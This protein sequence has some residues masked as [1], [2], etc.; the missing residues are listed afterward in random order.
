MNVVII[1]GGTR[2]LVLIDYFQSIDYIKIKGVVDTNA[3]APGVVRAKGLGIYTFTDINA[4]NDI[5]DVDTVIEVTGN[6]KARRTLIDLLKPNQHFMSS[7]AAKIMTDF[8][9]IQNLRRTEA[10]ESVSGEFN[11]LVST[12]KSSEEYIE[13]SMFKIE[14]VLQSM[15]IVTMN[16]RIEAARAGESGKAFDVVVQAMQDTLSNIEKVLRDIN[17]ASDESKHTIAELIETEKKLKESLTVH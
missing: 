8:I 5:P 13:H 11:N 2:S 14:E 7:K 15:K 4:L 6:E 3:Q 17:T 16:A 12:M 10:M 9:Q 1:G